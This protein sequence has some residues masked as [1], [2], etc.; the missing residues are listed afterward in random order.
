MT[1]ILIL[2]MSSFIIKDRVDSI[3]NSYYNNIKKYPNIDIIFY[4]D[5][6]DEHNDLVKKVEANYKFKYSD[7]EIKHAAAFKL[8]RDCYYKK[9]DWFLFVDDDTYVNVQALSN[10]INSFDENFIHGY[11]FKQLD[12]IS[13]GAGCLISNKLI[14]NFFDFITYNSGYAD[15]SLGENARRK[16][17]KFKHSDLFYASNPWYDNE[18]DPEQNIKNSINNRITYHYINKNQMQIIYEKYNK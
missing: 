14:H 4:S 8:I 11:Y 5:Y 16:N 10:N 17:I 3:M 7:N 18:K 13:G 15:V 9:Y 12:Y 1:N 2:V 6:N